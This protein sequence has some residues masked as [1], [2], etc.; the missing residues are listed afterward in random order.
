MIKKTANLLLVV[1]LINVR[2]TEIIEL[3]SNSDSRA[4]VIEGLITNELKNQ[5]IH[6]SYTTELDTVGVQPAT[7][8]SVKI[9][10]ID[11]NTTFL[12]NEDTPGVYKSIIP[13]AGEVGKTYQLEVTDVDD[14]RFYSDLETMPSPSKID[15]IQ[16]K[17]IKN[18]SDELGVSISTYS[19]SI[20]SNS[21]RYYL[22][23]WNE[24][25]E[26]V[27]PYLS[28]YRW[29]GEEAVLRDTGVS[30]CWKTESSNLIL[31][32]SAESLTENK[33]DDFQVRFVATE[34]RALRTRYSLN[35]FQ[36]S[37]SKKTFDYWNALGSFV[38]E[39][40]SLVNI[41]LGNLEGNISSDS[42]RISLGYF[43]V[44]SVDSLRKF[45]DPSQFQPD[46]FVKPDYPIACIVEVVPPRD[47]F[48]FMN[49]DQNS[50]K[51]VIHEGPD[52]SGGWALV[53][54]PCGD[55]RAFGTNLKPDFWIE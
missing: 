55:C 37:I 23:K 20:S 48:P 2:C 32:K 15:S 40:E 22:W 16:G 4:V 10:C 44:A 6:V 18:D 21:S 30:R 28:R 3:D 7:G 9:E 13:F 41:Q 35:L 12:F 26:I 27:T 17:F 46:G 36:Y 51:Y 45:F 53:L 29:T 31:T 39:N 34:E 33:I 50:E 43:T 49:A 52:Y 14:I 47:L 19:S 5:S 8:F 42:E 1:L 54:Q 11:D 24:T 38:N 25:F